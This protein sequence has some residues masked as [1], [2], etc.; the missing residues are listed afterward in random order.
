MDQYWRIG[1]FSKE[2]KKH[3]NTVDGWFKSLE[4]R[5]IHYVGRTNNEKIYDQ[6][7]LKIA[8]YIRDKRDLKPPWALDAIYDN[9][10]EQFELR[11][12]PPDFGL[13]DSQLMNFDIMRKLLIQEIGTT[14]ENIV[15]RR[16]EEGI[17]EI[18]KQLPQPIDPM[19][20]RQQR[21]TDLVT[22]RRVE[23]KLTE[24]ALAKWL[25]LPESERM[26]KVKSGFFSSRL[27][28]DV[29]KKERFIKSY[30][31]EKFEEQLKEQYGI[32]YDNNDLST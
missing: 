19:I 21:V 22:V 7:D 17:N 4:E 8:I 9:L 32:N 27:E 20:E 24:E 26:I 16:V 3:F 6:L 5:R 14:V 10:S 1:E 18:I 30:V 13:N 11:P 28:E 29:G 15:E 2:I 23:H 12:F 25:T 31:N